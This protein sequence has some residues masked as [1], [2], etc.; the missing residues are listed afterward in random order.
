MKYIWSEARDTR[1]A[2]LR[3]VHLE[4]A[5][6]ETGT[7]R[8]YGIAV[9]MEREDICESEEVNGITSDRACAEGVLKKLA[10]GT[11]TPCVLQEVLKELCAAL[12]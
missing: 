7:P 2:G 1:D 11:V 8:R 12:T 3:P 4:Y 5:L 9:R 6:T 10:D